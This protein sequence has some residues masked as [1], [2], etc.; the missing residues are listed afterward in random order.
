MLICYF[1]GS[2]QYLNFYFSKMLEL[3]RITR[4]LRAHTQLDKP[5]KLK[6]STDLPTLS[7]KLSKNLQ[8]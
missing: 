5:R 6:P 7:V 2:F 4:A 1:S 8:R 3:P